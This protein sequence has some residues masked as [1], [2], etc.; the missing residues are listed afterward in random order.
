MSS[1]HD[2]PVGHLTPESLEEYFRAGVPTSHL[3]SREPRC[4]LCIDPVRETFELFTPAVGSLPDVTGLQHVSV[5]TVAGEDGERF[6]LQV[7]ARNLRHEA[8][9]LVVSV[10]EEM[11][12]GSGFAASTGAALTAFRSIIAARSR[13]STDQQLG[14]MGELF[15]L[16]R[17]VDTAGEEQA[18]DW[19]LGPLAEQHDYAFPEFDAEIKT[20]TSDRR[21]HVISGTAQLQPSPGRALWLVSVQLTRA[22]GAK[23]FSL[24]GLVAQLRSRLTGRRE[25]FLEHLIRVGWRDQ[26]QDLYHAKYILRSGPAAFLIDEDFPA[27]TPRRLASAVPHAELVSALSYRVDVSGRTP[28]TPGTPLDL[29]LTDP[30]GGH[31]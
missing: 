11:R 20:T 19:W 15:V 28:G 14:L 26:D 6:R 29:F 24:S 13:L 25:R 12:A 2:D 22:G 8:Y 7:D 4:E 10:V 9:G 1:T 16:R 21:T 31:E 18:I 17:L 3:L 23:G 27:L 5:D 30:E